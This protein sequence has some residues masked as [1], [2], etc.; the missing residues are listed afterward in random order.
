MHTTANRCAPGDDLPPAV[1]IQPMLA[2]D[3][4][5]Q[6]LADAAAAAQAQG[7]MPP[8]DLPR[9]ALERPQKSENGDFASSL[10]LRLA[11]QARMNP[12]AIAEAIAGQV[13]L[14][15]PIGQISFAPPGFVNV[16]LSTSWLQAQVEAIIDAGDRF[17]NTE[18]GAG[19]SVQVEFVS[20][21]PT[22]PV[23]VGHARGAVLGSALANALAAA[24]FAVTREY[25]VNDAGTQMEIFYEST[26]VRYAQALG[27]TDEVLREDG[28]RGQYLTDLGQALAA[29]Y[30][31]R[32]LGM[33][34]AE[35]VTEI[36]AVGLER[37]LDGIRADLERIGVDFDVWFREHSLFESGQYDEAMAALSERGYTTKRDGA[38][39]F[40]STELGEDKD[41][42]IV[43]T[44]GQPTYFASDIAYHRDKL[45]G[46]KFNRVINIWGADHQ[47]H[48]ARMKAVLRALGIDDERLTII[49]SQLVTL[50]DG[51]DIV[52]ASKRTGQIVTLSDLVDEVGADACRYFFLAR[53]PESQMDFDLELAKKE[54]SENPVYYVQ[55]AH[56]R[57]AGILRQAAE[58]QITWSDGDASLLT[59]P[60]ELA[61]VRKMVQLPEMIDAIAVT[62][63]P[64]ALP[65]YAMELA[66]AFHWFYDHCRVLSSDPADEPLTKARLKLVDAAKIAL[67]RTLTLMGM[68]TPETM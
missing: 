31:D 63:A 28:Y 64:H 2:R 45:E 59:D 34:R 62:L 9:V 32:F 29:E 21:N 7:A 30:G 33:E 6:R 4:I 27:R 60:A 44:S 12:M 41:N 43:R 55:Y 39:W 57:I 5:A 66:T 24:G 40:K 17:G 61:L 11:K 13:G 58:R 56:A 42:V 3:V 36:G 10:A 53:T 19:R 16:T 25:Y 49:I 14:E 1:M 20:V 18:T 8:G 51:G 68:S 35:A 37:M 48:V 50:K 52:R 54:S 67:A 15:D 22:G 47:G 38:I 26:Y 23:H 65:H 46:R